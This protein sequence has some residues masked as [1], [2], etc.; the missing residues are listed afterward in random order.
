MIVSPRRLQQDGS[1]GCGIGFLI[2]GALFLVL[3]VI[4]IHRR[5]SPGRSEDS[6]F[7]KIWLGRL[8]PPSDPEPLPPLPN[9]GSST[10]PTSIQE[11][12]L[13]ANP[14]LILA[15]EFRAMHK[16]KCE[17]DSKIARKRRT[18]ILN[19]FEKHRVLR[20]RL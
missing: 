17:M 20:V 13:L 12:A 5:R 10:S 3:I 19:S 6:Q 14:S 1:S 11:D 15:P 7:F 2:L 18:E 9:N 8:Q 16:H 4:F